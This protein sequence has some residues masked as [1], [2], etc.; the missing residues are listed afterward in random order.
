M[1]KG[2]AIVAAGVML[3]AA[4]GREG[5]ENQSALTATDSSAVPT[6]S[7]ASDASAVS[8][9]SAA[10][11]AAG[12]VSGVSADASAQP[13]AT[14]AAAAAPAAV[15]PPPEGRANPPR[16]GTYTYAYSGSAS[17]PFNPTAPPSKFNGTLTND[18][19]HSG[20]V[21]TSETTNSETPGRTTI[22]TRHS[23]VKVEMLSLKTESPAGE[24]ACTFSPPL[25]I[26]KFPIKPETYPQQPLKGEGNACDGTLDITIVK[27]ETVKDGNGRA[28]STWQAK[29]K[30]TLNSDQ[31]TITQNETRWVSPDL[32][33]EIRSNGSTEGK[34]ATQRFTTT[35]TSALKKHP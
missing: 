28:W 9:S 13:N 34:Y 10:P 16:D 17:D 24:F 3:F 11:A 1:K 5:A 31:L 25:L 6:A 23:S 14:A 33:V 20:N 26:T 7:A 18:I 2:L 30:T 4:C 35:S 21:Y 32:G 22:R 29:I 12:A 15:K 8:G 27:K 19:T